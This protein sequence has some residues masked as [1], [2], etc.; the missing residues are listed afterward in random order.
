[1]AGM[2]W[3]P[4]IEA[5]KKGTTLPAASGKAPEG[6]LSAT[7]AAGWSNFTSDDGAT[8]SAL[9]ESDHAHMGSVKSGYQRPGPHRRRTPTPTPAAPAP[10]RRNP[11][12]SS[13][14]A[15]VLA[16]QICRTAEFASP[17][18]ARGIPR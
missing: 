15:L 3:L 17:D 11:A 12:A 10:C 8:V 6:C 1:M 7:A 13:L 4:Q 16:D 14:A 18:F 5:P 2:P 9:P